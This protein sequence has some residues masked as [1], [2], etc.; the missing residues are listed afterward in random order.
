MKE[1]FENDIA[2]TYWQ[3]RESIKDLKRNEQPD[4]QFWI[5]VI[6]GE[7]RNITDMVSYRLFKDFL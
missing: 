3:I 5:H 4:S 7:R 1:L 2:D 6:T